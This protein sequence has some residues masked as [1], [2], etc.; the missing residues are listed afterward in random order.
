MYSNQEADVCKVK[1]GV[2]TSDLSMRI[3]GSLIAVIV[4]ATVWV[5]Y[6]CGNSA[7]KE[8]PV[9]ETLA[10]YFSPPSQIG[11]DMGDFRSPLLFESGERV[12]DKAD[13]PG[14]RKEILEKWHHTMGAWPPII[15]HPAVEYLDSA[16]RGPIIQRHVKIEVAPG[17]TREA[18]LLVPEAKGPLPAALVVYYD[19]ETGVGLGTV[20]MRDF[21]YQLAKRGFVTLSVGS[22]YD[23]NYYPSKDSATLQPLSMLA[24]MSANCYEMLADL[25][26]VDAKRVGV[27]GHSYGGKWAMFSSCLY[28][29]FALGVW[30]D[31]GVVFDET[32]ENVNY[33]EPWYLGYEKG[34]WRQEGI[35]TKTNGRTGA[36]RDMIANKMDLVELHALMAPRPFLVSGGSE[37]QVGRWRALNHAVEVNRFLGYENRVAMHNRPA[38]GPTEESNEVIYQF[39]EFFLK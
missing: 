3:P 15:E 39:F 10:P 19:P 11:Q 32:R 12:A 20:K 26:Y 28:D 9:P 21:A 17:W 27:V 24:Y 2:R 30:S 18:Y 31:G 35:P 1:T 5:L 23:S 13:W 25:P 38:H 37:D 7:V 29:K 4:C 34:T 22:P 16:R 6:G 36:Y 8:R 33:W 14:R